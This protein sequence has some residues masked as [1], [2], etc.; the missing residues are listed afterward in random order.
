M[1][2]VST[3]HAV[4]QIMEYLYRNLISF[5]GQRF[6]QLFLTIF[7]HFRVCE[8]HYTNYIYWMWFEECFYSIEWDVNLYKN[9]HYWFGKV[10]DRKCREI[11]WG[12]RGTM[13][14]VIRTVSLELVL[15]SYCGVWHVLGPMLGASLITEFSYSTHGYSP[16]WFKVI[17]L[18][19]YTAGSCVLLRFS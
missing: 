6:W 17:P 9:Y 8:N 18:Y 10:F 13:K 3:V 14:S 16:P 5:R 19:V 4:K 11:A 7:V 1:G 15:T 2:C 12:S